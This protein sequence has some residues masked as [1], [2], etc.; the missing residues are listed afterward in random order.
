MTRGSARPRP[1]SAHPK[2]R[3]RSTKAPAPRRGTGRGKTR[4]PQSRAGRPTRA[5]RIVR[6]IALVLLL[7]LIATLV[8]GCAVY[9]VMARQLPDPDLANARGRDQSTVILDRR[10]KEITKLFAEEN[11]KDVPLSD[12]P[13]HLKQAVIAT[14]DRRFYEHEGVDPLSIGRALLVDIVRR[15]KAQGGSTIT[16]QY[17][18]QAFV[19]D[20][21]TLKR[22]IQEAILAQR[23]EA[24]YSKDQILERY[25]NT[26]YFG[27]GAYGVEAASRVYFGKSVKKVSLPEAAMLA[28]VVK[29]PGRYSPYLEPEN[30]RARRDTVLGQMLDQG[31]IDDLRHAEAVAAEIE[32]EGLK[33]RANAA[34]YFVEWVKEQL[35][36]EYGERA[37]YRGG[38]SVK[39]TLDLKMQRAAQKAIASALDE[40]DDPSAALVAVEPGTGAVLAMVGGR[41]FAT[42]QFN[43]AVQGRRQPGSA[44][45]TFVLATALGE[46]VSPEQTYESGPAKL[47]VNGSV[48]RVT[49]ASGSRTGPMRL[50]PA[51]E[52]SVNSVFAQLILD[53]GPEDVKD[54]AEKMGID[55][56]IEAVPAIALGG[57]DRGVS[58]LGMA[59]SYAT[60][61]AGGVHAESFGVLSV[62]GPDGGV[63]EKHEAKTKRA[64]DADVA[65][66]T[67]DILR[68]VISR[69]TGT[70]ARLDRPAAGKTGTTQQYRDAW[71]AGYTPDIAC[72]VW[73]GYPDAQREMKSVHGQSVTG[74][75]FPARIW[76]AFMSKALDGRPKT[77]F[78]RPRGLTR[79]TVCSETGLAIT[80]FCPDPI[81]AL[82]LSS[83]EVESCTVHAT[84]TEVK[85]PKLV[86][87][88]KS[89]ALAALQALGLTAR[90]SEQPVPGVAAGMVAEQSPRAGTLIKV[91]KPVSI[92]VSAGDAGNALPVAI[93]TAPESVRAGH[94][95][96][97]DGSASTDDGRI[98]TYYW[99]FGDGSTAEGKNVNHTW[100]TAGTFDVT[101]WVTDDMGGQA[102]TTHKV[103]VR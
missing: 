18:K 53:V 60:L 77:E 79:R 58:P 27:H 22:K 73:V 38:L 9:A 1:R 43:V 47:D 31:L 88:S 51:T 98:V 16:Q 44:F 5:T 30:A 68:G 41:D 26:I 36:K 62:T 48:W 71:F 37:V 70:A 11:R 3:A 69:G 93:F 35:I 86:G 24:R 4:P 66:L 87:L 54:T 61:A 91:T 21:K 75:S 84:P 33:P 78:E 23:V 74:G 72:A 100:A 67:T 101:L 12:M 56:G 28:G 92:V 13:V 82:M 94:P 76:H 7:V 17:V 90:V 99:E 52:Q 97:L 25:L 55:K 10:G 65:Y 103:I 19:T 96:V 81:K 2:P 6:R 14:E 50:R 102:S 63:L 57:L 42:Q 85:V 29:S 95:E 46:G 59:E 20:E 89:D 15:E 34:P 40:K 49:G 45:K 39:T 83:S 8:T 32:L 80:P 64:L